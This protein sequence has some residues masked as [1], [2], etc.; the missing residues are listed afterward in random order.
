[1]HKPRSSRTVGDY[2]VRSLTEGLEVFR[3]QPRFFEEFFKSLLLRRCPGFQKSGG[4]E[5][6]DTV[7]G[8]AAASE[9]GNPAPPLDEGGDDDVLRGNV[10]CSARGTLMPGDALMAPQGAC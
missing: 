9:E 6:K 4:A 8:N 2:N 10:T 7:V 5:P 1:M 3:L